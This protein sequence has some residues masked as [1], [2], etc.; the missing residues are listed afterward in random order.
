MMWMLTL[1]LAAPPEGVDPDDFE[2]WEIAA[3]KA[4]DGPEGCW[5][6]TGSL[7]ID[8]AMHSPSTAFTRSDTARFVA[9]GGWTGR[10]EDGQWSRFEYELTTVETPDD[11]EEL[12]LEVPVF[13]VIGRIDQSVVVAK[14]PPPPEPKEGETVR[15]NNV[16]IQI[17][18]DDDEEGGD[19]MAGGAEAINL[20]QSFID[21]WE[22]STAI[23]FAQWSESDRHIELMQEFP[24]FQTPRSPVVTTTSLFPEGG[25]GL[26][27]LDAVFPKRV[28]LGEWP[29]KVTLMDTQF[30]LRQQ[31]VGTTWLPQVEGFTLMAG[32]LGFTFGYEQQIAYATAQACVSEP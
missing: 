30:H 12:N 5:E 8:A 13:P 18:G 32:V 7:R 28:K 17:G 19:G 3:D 27:R 20:F 16:S 21:A 26:V 10:L 6:L 4:L 25:E 29:L 11:E 23:S 24:L 1:A 15:R 31:R 2:R 14:K 22:P 9:S